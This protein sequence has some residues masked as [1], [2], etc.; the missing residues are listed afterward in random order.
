MKIG[1]DEEFGKHLENL[2]EKTIRTW[3]LWKKDEGMKSVGD[4]A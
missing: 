2:H 3:L 1:W 4:Y